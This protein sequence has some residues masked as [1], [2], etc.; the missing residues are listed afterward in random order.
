MSVL[1]SGIRCG[2]CR[3]PYM[4][5]QVGYSTRD[6]AAFTALLADRDGWTLLGGRY[7]CPKHALPS[8]ETAG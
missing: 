5:P 2:V 8:A 3:R 1:L 4:H 6:D 7:L